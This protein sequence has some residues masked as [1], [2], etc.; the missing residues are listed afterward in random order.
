MSTGTATAKKAAAS[1]PSSPT[2]AG[3][4][5]PAG[6]PTPGP[7]PTPE[8]PQA[9]SPD[10]APEPVTGH[11]IL[12][13]HDREAALAEVRRQVT[14][15]EVGIGALLRDLTPEQVR[16]EA[17]DVLAE[18]GLA[19]E[20]MRDDRP[21][22]V[23]EAIAEVTRRVGHIAKEGRADARSGG[24]RF[25]GIDDVLAALHPILGDVGLVLMPGRIV[26]HRRETRST[27]GSPLNV[28]ILTVGYTLIGPDGSREYG[29][30]VG[31]GGDTG[32]KATQ[33]A[34]SQAYKSWALQA[35]SIPT[36]QSAADEPDA[37]NPA[38]RPF[39]DDERERA[40]TAWTAGRA[41]GDMARLVAVR[42][43]AVAEGLLDVPVGTADGDVPLGLLLDRRRAEVERATAGGAS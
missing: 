34:M 24:Y 20:P 3:P 5:E 33:K 31:E 27:S 6:E 23:H 37:T 42:Q 38:S 30:A 11:S 8:Q 1:R 35:F 22:T 13:A 18:A 41:A 16:D 40:R 10:P 43:Q 21:L 26:D 32:D 2:P 7:L 39:S 9:P 17:L 36:E 14:A 25:R 12:A 29:E 28:A 19:A 4:V 15:G